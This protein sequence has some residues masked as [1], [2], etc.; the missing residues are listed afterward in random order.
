MI[1]FVPTLEE[2]A[3]IITE[4]KD[5]K[6]VVNKEG[7]RQFSFITF[8][9]GIITNLNGRSCSKESLEQLFIDKGIRV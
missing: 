9:G 2:A 6:L 1:N 8:K 5:G 4:K 3:K 7:S